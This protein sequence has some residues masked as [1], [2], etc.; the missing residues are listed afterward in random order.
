MSPFEIHRA[1]S[2]QGFD[3]ISVHSFNTSQEHLNIVGCGVSNI[4]NCKSKIVDIRVRHRNLYEVS[5]QVP[6][7]NRPACFLGVGPR[8]AGRQSQLGADNQ[9][10]QPLL[11]HRYDSKHN[12]AKRHGPLRRG[13]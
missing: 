12:S 10:L 11:K 3:C 8:N 7:L 6:T 5:L 9:T 13:G 4:R 2:F 1:E